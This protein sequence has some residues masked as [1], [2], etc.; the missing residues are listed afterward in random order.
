M[1]AFASNLRRFREEK[2]FSADHM[3]LLLEMNES[4]YLDLENGVAAPSVPVLKLLSHIFK[5]PVSDLIS[6]GSLQQAAGKSPGN[7]IAPELLSEADKDTYIRI[8]ENQLR[9]L[10]AEKDG[11]S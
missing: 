2:G 5:M 3:A 9:I 11:A 4:A 8:L 10:L 7:H 6:N 1:E